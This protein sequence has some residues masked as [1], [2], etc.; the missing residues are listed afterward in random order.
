MN[1]KGYYIYIQ[2]AVPIREE[3][4]GLKMG[5]AGEEPYTICKNQFKY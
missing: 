5:H 1:I 3:G 4:E 2:R